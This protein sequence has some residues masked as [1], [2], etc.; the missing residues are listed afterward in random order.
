M[1]AL[2]ESR[3]TPVLAACGVVTVLWLLLPVRLPQT[4][5]EPSIADC[6]TLA[7][8]PAHDLAALERCHAIVPADLE[9][10]GD[11]GA[12]Y[13][14]AHRP[15]DAVR[16]YRKIIEGDPHYAAIRLRLA[17]LLR[18]RG[19]LPGARAE[20]EAAARIQPNRPSVIDSQGDLKP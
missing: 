3:V 11:L 13:E 1:R 15:D 9:L 6:L 18:D 4:G 16:I 17:R 8:S 14:A 12:A 2:R 20:F 10:A 5:N 19:D 7:D